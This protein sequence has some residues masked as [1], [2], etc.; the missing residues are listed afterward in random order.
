MPMLQVQ[1]A[2]KKIIERYID[3]RLPLVSDVSSGSTTIEV[4]TTRRFN[5][6]ENVVVYTDPD[7]P[8]AEAEGEVHEVEEIVDNTHMTLVDP[9]LMDYDSDDSYV[10][11]LL[12]YDPSEHN[13]LKHIYLGDPEV[14]MRFPAITI[15]A[16]TRESE[17]LTLESTSETYN[18][19]IAV[20]VEASQYE[21]QYEL[22]HSYIAAIEASLF[23]S[24]YPLVEPYVCTQLAEDYEPTDLTIKV[25]DE[26]AFSCTWGVVFLENWDYTRMARIDDHLGSGVYQLRTPIGREFSAGDNVILPLTHIYNSLPHSTQY[27]TVAKGTMLKAGIISW[28]G[29]EEVR[30]SVP[31]ID[32]LNM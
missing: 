5:E 32:P 7:D 29:V 24:F 4:P 26:E 23:R 15:D 17:W 22:M 25:V 8:T 9:L 3:G 19:D 16:K 6:G 20:Y 30:R 10:K 18:I 2:L 28:R 31:W 12:G 27:G 14:I 21:F 11:K 13:F 1:Q